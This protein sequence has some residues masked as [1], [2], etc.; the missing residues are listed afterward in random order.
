MKSSLVTLHNANGGRFVKVT[1]SSTNRVNQTRIRGEALH[2]IRIQVQLPH[3]VCMLSYC[4][5]IAQPVSSVRCKV[6]MISL[7]LLCVSSKRKHLNK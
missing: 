2:P 7:L 5:I 1:F 4:A 3:Q 6:K